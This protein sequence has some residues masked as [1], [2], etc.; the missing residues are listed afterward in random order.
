[1]SRIKHQMA[2]SKA[3]HSFGQLDFIEKFQFGHLNLHIFF[4]KASLK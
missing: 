1:M 4:P 3:S 2:V